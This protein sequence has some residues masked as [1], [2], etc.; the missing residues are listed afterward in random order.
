LVFI[1]ELS[2]GRLLVLLLL[3]SLTRWYNL[4]LRPLHYDEILYL[5]RAARVAA[6]ADPLL[7]L[8][9]GAMKTTHLWLIALVWPLSPDPIWVGRFAMTLAGL[10]GIVGIYHCGVVLFASRRVGLLAAGF[11]LICPALFLYERAI[12]A[13]T[14][15]TAL[16]C[17]ILYGV[18]AFLLRG[19]RRPLWWLGPVLAFALLAKPS[20]LFFL[21]IPA[22]GYLLFRPPLKRVLLALLPLAVGMSLALA[23]LWPL[24]VD[25]WP[26]VQHHTGLE[27]GGGSINIWERVGH[28]LAVSQDWVITIFSP[29]LVL[30]ALAGLGMALWEGRSRW[31]AVWLALIFASFWF[32]LALAAEVWYPRY[33]LPLAVPLVLLAGYGVDL[34]LRRLPTWG[35]AVAITVLLSPALYADF[36]LLFDPPRAP[37]HPEIRREY[38]TDWPSAYGLPEVVT[39]VRH[40]AAEY[41]AIYVAYNE[42]VMTEQAIPYYLPDPPA[43]VEFVV[44]DP[45]DGVML[46]QIN[47]LSRERPTFFIL[48]TARE[49]GMKD[50]LKD[51]S[52]FPQAHHLLHVPRPDGLTGWDVYQWVPGE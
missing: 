48:N 52:A 2:R 47:D 51:P 34:T 33:L 14:L 31:R 8:K 19:D 15:L 28:N 24:L 18:A 11:Y 7:A 6:K 41:P 25:F 38:I 17:W 16:E 21:A 3:Y 36:W 32:A 20:G 10:L 37:L 26:T 22:F 29:P 40:L 35:V 5:E 23:L 9:I 46:Y 49:K 13:D 44:I 43:N 27:G 1:R 39:F 50:F 45:F 4:T 30:L 12:V 42:Q